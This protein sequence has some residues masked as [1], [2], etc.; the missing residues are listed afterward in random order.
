[1]GGKEADT[2]HTTPVNPTGEGANDG[3][4]VE[5]PSCPIKPCPYS[6][7]LPSLRPHPLPP[8]NVTLASI[9]ELKEPL[10]ANN[11]T[12]KAPQSVKRKSDILLQATK[13]VAAQTAALSHTLHRSSMAS[14]HGKKL[15]HDNAV[16]YRSRK[17]DLA[18]FFMGRGRLD[19][20]EG[21]LF[22]V[23]QEHLDKYGTMHIS[24][25]VILLSFGILEEMRNNH[26]LARAY[27]ETS[28]EILVLLVGPL[29]REAKRASSHLVRSLLSVGATQDAVHIYDVLAGQ[30]GKHHARHIRDAAEE[31]MESQGEVVRNK[32]ITPRVVAPSPA[33]NASPRTPPMFVSPPSS[34]PPS[35]PQPSSPSSPP[36]ENKCHAIA[37][38]W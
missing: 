6:P 32:I 34:P 25:P 17:I 33:G 28:F 14:H 31:F 12:H 36:A 35:S 27:R 7:L 11:D 3:E 19:E 29:H 5:S 38:G 26:P 8:V 16:Y 10:D 21:I 2:H 23:L 13:E 1:M 22:N 24:I 37:G 18:E 15:T 30:L 4:R 20:A 9:K